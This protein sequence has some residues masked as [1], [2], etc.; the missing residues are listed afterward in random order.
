MEFKILLND[1]R[2]KTVQA[3]DIDGAYDAVVKETG[4]TYADVMVVMPLATVAEYREKV[5]K[6]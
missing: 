6:E 5:G 4:C 1:G 3:K 2:L